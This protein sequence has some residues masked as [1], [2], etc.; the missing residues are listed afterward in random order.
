MFDD[1]SDDDDSRSTF[2]AVPDDDYAP[3]PPKPEP[4]QQAVQQPLIEGGGVVTSAQPSVS[5]HGGSAPKPGKR[6]WADRAKKMGQPRNY[7]AKDGQVQ[8]IEAIKEKDG[9]KICKRDTERN[10]LPLWKFNR[11]SVLT[12]DDN[13][14][15]LAMMIN[16]QNKGE[17][18]YKDNRSFY[19]EV[20][21]ALIPERELIQKLAK[22][23]YERIWKD[24]R[25]NCSFNRRPKDSLSFVVALQDA[26]MENPLV[27]GILD[28]NYTLVKEISRPADA[29]PDLN[30]VWDKCVLELGRIPK[31]M[32][33]Q[34][35]SR[36]GVPIFR[37]K[38]DTLFPPGARRD[39]WNCSEDTN[40]QTLAETHGPQVVIPACTLKIFLNTFDHAGD[41]LIPVT[42]RTTY[43]GSRKVNVLTFEKPLPKRRFTNRE[44]VEKFYKYGVRCVCVRPFHD[45]SK[46]EAYRK[47]AEAAR[48]QKLGLDAGSPVRNG[49]G[50]D[51]GLPGINGVSP[52]GAGSGVNNQASVVK[53]ENADSDSDADDGLKIDEDGPTSPKMGKITSESGDSPKLPKIRSGLGN[54][55]D[56]DKQNATSKEMEAARVPG[57]P[58]EVSQDVKPS[59]GASQGFD[60][61]SL[62]ADLKAVSGVDVK[63]QARNQPEIRETAVSVDFKQPPGCDKTLVSYDLWKFDDYSMLVRSKIDG[64]LN[65]PNEPTVTFASTVEYMCDFGGQLM[66]EWERV[67]LLSTCRLKKAERLMLAHLHPCTG[68]VLAFYPLTSDRLRASISNDSVLAGYSGLKTV[69]NEL[70]A[71]PDG[72]YVVKHVA[73]EPSVTVLTPAKVSGNDE[74]Q[75]LLGESTN[76]WPDVKL[77]D[78]GFG[79]NNCIINLDFESHYRPLDPS[80]IFQY[81]RLTK[82]VPVTFDVRELN[83]MPQL[84]PAITAVPS[85][86]SIYFEPFV[87]RIVKSQTGCCHRIFETKRAGKKNANNK[88]NKKNGGKKGGKAKKPD[89]RAP[90]KYEDFDVPPAI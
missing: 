19:Q 49:S 40:M 57:P 66:P 85:I 55:E 51:N 16:L 34:M 52:E 43:F 29:N 14:R 31:A 72:K 9:P 89:V 23:A 59:Q 53:E 84:D 65:V 17:F 10:F 33:P 12:K 74:V 64:R 4:V 70:S 81:H 3:P 28:S 69:L 25:K 54:T 79:L 61:A 75:C 1:S 35:H 39:R 60:P 13:R 27:R 68:E 11:K 77:E 76:L 50:K 6:K 80:T 5:G 45:N 15:F 73:F 82:R 88:Q 32:V 2:T 87:G 90:V 48:K 42:V 38:I 71:L 46:V 26:K 21:T 44:A 78:R 83:E 41:F 67:R 36:V 20:T 24:D 62:L 37:D 8:N 56:V 47:R 58:V 18:I 7:D 30:L 22:T 63:S 86:L